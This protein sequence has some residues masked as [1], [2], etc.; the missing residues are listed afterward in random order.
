MWWES[1]TS[2]ISSERGIQT[3]RFF[4]PGAANIALRVRDLAPILE[5]LRKS[6]VAKVITDGGKPAAINGGQY[7]FVQDPDGFVVELAQGTPPRTR[8][9]RRR[10]TSSAPRSR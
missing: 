2:L 9:R 4:D 3:P 5:R 1:A 8:R 6:G 10:A 7:L